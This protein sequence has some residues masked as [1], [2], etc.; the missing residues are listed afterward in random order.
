NEIGLSCFSP[1]G[2]FYVFPSIAKTGMT[3]EQFCDELFREKRVSV[4]PGTAFGASGEGFV[5]I[6]Y[7]YS[8]EHLSEGVKRMAEFVK[9][10]EEKA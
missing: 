7:S 1:E 5:R 6:S 4:I 2:A 9:K 10:L 3:S 8:I